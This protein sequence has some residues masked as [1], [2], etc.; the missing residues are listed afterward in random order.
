MIVDIRPGSPTFGLWI[1][2]ELSGDSGNALFISEGLGH[3][4]LALQ[5]NTAVAYLVST[6][7][8]PSDEF[9]IN[10]LDEKIGIN[11]GMSTTE[12]KIS[13]KDKNAA[14]LSERFNEGNL[15]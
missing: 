9:E 11:W 2:V 5:D 12:L 7:F 3:G 6:P 8:S 4:F 10:P 14:T 15:P 1:E 13:D